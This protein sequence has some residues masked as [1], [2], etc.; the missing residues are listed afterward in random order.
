M[1]FKK[2]ILFLLFSCSFLSAQ[3]PEE[4]NIIVQDSVQIP[5]SSTTINP[6][7][8]ARAAFYSAILP[9]L[10]QVYN[11][12]YWK[13][14]IIYG[15]IGTSLY[16]YMDSNKQ[17]HKYRDAYKMRLAGQVDEFKGQYN[18]Q[19]LINAQRQFQRNRDMSLL[20]T[21]GLYALNIIEANV[22]AH[23]TQFNVNDNLSFTPTLI[24]DEINYKHNFGA[25]V[26]FTF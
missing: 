21:L 6:L 17:Y 14:P 25:S 7:A 10:G 1:I 19:T 13:V 12:S 22:H 16:F 15:A 5:S 26:K 8:P 4:V 3:N 9:G 20:I 2:H 23:L 24:Q 18:D 11:K